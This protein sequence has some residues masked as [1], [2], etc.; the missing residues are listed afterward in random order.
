MVVQRPGMPLRSVVAAAASFALVLPC[1]DAATVATSNRLSKT[2]KRLR[3]YQQPGSEEVFGTSEENAHRVGPGGCFNIWKNSASHCMVKTKCADQNIDGYSFSL[4]C[5]DRAD[6]VVRHAFGSNA[7]DNEEEFDTLIICQSCEPDAVEEKKFVANLPEGDNKDEVKRLVVQVPEKGHNPD[8]VERLKVNLPKAGV[9]QNAQKELTIDVP[10]RDPAAKKPSLEEQVTALTG[11]V[12]ELKTDMQ[13]AE[14]A[15]AKLQDRVAAVQPP[16][17]CPSC[18]PSAA[19]PP[20]AAA[21]AAAALAA[22]AA[23]APAAV[24]PVNL[25]VHHRHSHKKNKKKPH[26]RRHKRVVEEEDDA[27][28]DD[29]QEEVSNPPQPPP[30]AAFTSSSEQEEGGDEEQPAEDQE[31]QQTAASLP[32]ARKGCYMNLNELTCGGMCVWNDDRN[33]CEDPAGNRA[34]ADSDDGASNDAPAQPVTLVADDS[35]DSQG[36]SQDSAQDSEETGDETSSREETAASDAG[37]ADASESE[38]EGA[39]AASEEDDSQPAAEAP[40]PE[41]E[42]DEE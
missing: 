38:D 3:H 4:V 25:R 35:E 21:P 29:E 36:S 17:P 24:A 22:P 6:G 23:P 1:A 5:K 28:D 11:E 26:P 18:A 31:Q 19:A 30:Q 33:A 34:S 2:G 37:S 9:D 32:N 12:K 42:S 40:Q 7:F 39:A 27:Q 41:P 10:E 15:V 16:P 8:A 14:N 20:V 13:M